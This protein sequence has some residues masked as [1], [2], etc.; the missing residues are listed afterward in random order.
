MVANATTTFIDGAAHLLDHLL[1]GEDLPI[2]HVM[3]KIRDL[4]EERLADSRIPPAVKEDPTSSYGDGD[5]HRQENGKLA[6]A[7]S[8]GYT[9]RRFVENV[10]PV[11]SKDTPSEQRPFADDSTVRRI[12][13]NVTPSTSTAAPLYGDGDDRREENEEPAL[14]PLEERYSEDDSAIRTFV[15]NVASLKS[16]DAPLYVDAQFLMTDTGD[17]VV[18]EFSAECRGGP[19]AWITVKSPAGAL[20]HEK[21][22]EYLRWRINGLEWHCGTMDLDDF[23]ATVSGLFGGAR[24]IYMKGYSKIT[25]FTKCLG[26]S[27]R[28]FV[29]PIDLPKLEILRTEVDMPEECPYHRNKRRFNCAKWNTYAMVKKSGI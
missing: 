28:N 8:D 1:S 4:L 22:N 12:V 23:G 6:L 21:E 29:D 7:P 16:T 27:R 20:P 11:T 17:Y 9:V 19:R 10:T 18:K 14:T 13:E 15:E 25:A 24:M 26:I 2:P 5:D 3:R